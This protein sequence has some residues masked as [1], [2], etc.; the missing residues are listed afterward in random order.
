[1]PPPKSSE[2]PKD[3]WFEFLILILFIGVFGITLLVLIFTE[4]YALK[5]IVL[6]VLDKFVKPVFLILDAILIFGIAY[7]WVQGAKLRPRYSIFKEPIPGEKPVEA[8]D[9]EIGKRW[10]HILERAARGT[11]GDLRLAIIEADALVDLCLKKAGYQG[12]HMS[13]RLSQIDGQEI[14]SLEML[15][16]AHKL[17]NDVVHTPGFAVS[18]DD[19]QIALKSFE[20]FMKDLGA[21]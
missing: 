4:L 13:D 7:C 19:A 20:V 12:E 16:R 14:G 15:W 6:S 10:V 21:L 3:Y 17:R 9:P 18:A 11:P 1:M 8:K 5:D 2:P